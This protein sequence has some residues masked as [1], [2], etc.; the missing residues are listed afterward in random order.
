MCISVNDPPLSQISQAKNLGITLV[1]SLVFPPH[2]HFSEKSV[3]SVFKITKYN[4]LQQKSNPILP[5]SDFPIHLNNIQNPY[6]DLLDPLWC[7]H[8]L[9]LW[10]IY[11]SPLTALQLCWPYWCFSN[12]PSNT[13]I[14]GTSYL[15]HLLPY[16]LDTHVGH[17]LTSL[18]SCSMSGLFWPPSLK[19]HPIIL[20]SISRLDFFLGLI[21]TCCYITYFLI[22]SLTGSSI[23]IISMKVEALLFILHCSFSSKLSPIS[24]E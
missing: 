2:I 12:K 1:S 16:H 5:S 10:P 19:T 7:G 6:T 9:P 17:S 20:Y 23:G 22:C 18:R 4:P 3:S 24:G 21:S 8:W 15:L 14:W 11:H 13:S